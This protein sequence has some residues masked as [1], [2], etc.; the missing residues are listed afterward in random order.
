MVDV[1]LLIQFLVSV[2]GLAALIGAG[3]FF[4]R[5]L[6][7]PGQ[8]LDTSAARPKGRRA[9]RRPVRSEPRGHGQR[10]TG[11][12]GQQEPARDTRRLRTPPT[13]AGAPP[14]ARRAE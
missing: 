5:A 1:P 14:T 10:A 8:R 9:A 13:L 7:L 11:A 12:R 2:V 4:D 3:W 6:R